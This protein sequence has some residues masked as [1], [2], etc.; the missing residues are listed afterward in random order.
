MP[1]SRR[2]GCSVR[3]PASGAV[4][5]SPTRR[6]TSSSSRL[7]QHARGERVD[8]LR[9]ASSRRKTEQSRRR[10]ALDK[11]TVAT[12]RGHRNRQAAELRALGLGY[13][14]P[15]LVFCREDGTLF[16]PERV[17]QMF[18]GHVRTAGLPRIPLK[19]LCRTRASLALQTGVNPQVVSERLGHAT[20]SFTLDSTPTA[21]A[22]RD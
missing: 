3:P 7:D 8:R 11:A 6:R 5:Q 4:R 16:H 2:S 22:A 18:R 17:S 13:E 21:R 15:G 19:N 1:G 10:V 9:V 20:V 12:L 14:D